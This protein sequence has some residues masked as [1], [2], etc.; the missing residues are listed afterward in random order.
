MIG[1]VAGM[2]FAVVIGVLLLVSPF[3]GGRNGEAGRPAMAETTKEVQGIE[4]AAQPRVVG[5]WA[6][7][8]LG[9]SGHFVTTADINFTD[10]TAVID[11]GA[12]AVALSWED[13]ENIG[14]DPDFLD[15]VRPVNTANGVVQAAPVT[16]KR[17]AIGGVTV[18]D[19]EAWV[20]PKGA[21]RG[22]LIG[23][24]FLSRLAGYRVEDG[25]LVLEQ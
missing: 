15:F 10:V 25:K 2:A 20:L 17:V 5:G 18:N 7:I 19:V 3:M 4:R 23:M 21:M 16:L 14:L 1:R 11:T 8:A 12:S 13:A 22:T 6:E 24:S 9:R